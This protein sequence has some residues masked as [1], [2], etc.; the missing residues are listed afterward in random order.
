[1]VSQSKMPLKIASVTVLAGLL[2]LGVAVALRSC[3]QSHRG[4]WR[5]TTLQ[6]RAFRSYVLV[7]T[8]GYRTTRRIPGPTLR[9]CVTALLADK[10]IQR[11]VKANCPFL[12]ENRDGWGRPFVFVWEQGGRRAVIRT[13][14]RNGRDEMGKGDD[15][16]LVM[17][18]S[19]REWM[20]P[21]ETGP[22]K[23]TGQPASEPKRRVAGE[24]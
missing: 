16:E 3:I 21:A 2:V 17:D 9:K 4:G 12:I 18:L 15:Y 19:E 6:M 22:A 1:M 8:S 14:G 7:Y 10:E 13:V 20:D 23:G 11:G 24:T 5:S